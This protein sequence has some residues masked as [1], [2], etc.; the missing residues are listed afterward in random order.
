MRYRTLGASGFE[1]SV[2]SY[3]AWQVGDPGY[4]GEDGEADSAA[5]V[6]AAIDAGVN[7]FDTAEMYGGG[8]SE[9]ALGRALGGKRDRVILASKVLGVNC[10]PDALRRACESSLSRLGT[11]YLDLYQVHWPCRETPFEATY[12]AME[13]LRQEGKI[14]AIGV[15]NFGRIDLETWLGVGRCVSDQLGYNLAFRAIEDEILP[16]CRRHGVGA[17][18]YMPLLQ[19]VLSYRWKS[20]DAIPA[21]RRRTRHFSGRRAG[22]RHGEA[23]CEDLLFGAL[24]QLE[25]LAG[26]AGQ[27]VATVALAW[28][29]AQPGITS[30][31]VGARNVGQLE[32]NLAAVD[33]ALEPEMLEEIDRITGPMKAYF[34]GNADMWAGAG[35]SR[36]R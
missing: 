21:M 17:L 9:R 32:R 10:A 8:E 18:V 35:E 5:A 19:G 6:A 15:S 27:P 14:R 26:A 13:G 12:E 36:I 16:A 28:A 3:G 11:D 7:L 22:V 31:I 20:A 33:L 23:G 24:R 34:G 29:M 2:L 4:W 1:V 30:V 25:E